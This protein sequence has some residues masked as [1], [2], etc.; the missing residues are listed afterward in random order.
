[1]VLLHY[2]S[3]LHTVAVQTLYRYSRS[4]LSAAH[5]CTQ[6]L[7]QYIPHTFLFAPQLRKEA[8][9]YLVFILRI[10]LVS[11]GLQEVL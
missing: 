2:A 1:V 3:P 9:V 4:A 8:Q 7:A 10:M 5:R 11:L 6:L